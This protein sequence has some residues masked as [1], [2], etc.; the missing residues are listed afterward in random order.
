MSI[1]ELCEKIIAAGG[2]VQL[3]NTKIKHS[4]GQDVDVYSGDDLILYIFS[5]KISD[6]SDADVISNVSI[7]DKEVLP[8]IDA[9]IEFAQYI[10]LIVADIKPVEI[11][12]IVE[13]T[14]EVEK[15]SPIHM[16]A[17]KT[18]IVL[19]EQLQGKVEAYEKILMGRD[20]TVGK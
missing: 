5:S 4:V 9:F 3:K 15:E 20:I 13:K 17:M 19:K 11:E 7:V 16:E 6:N 14:V 2:V 10:G 8:K 12:K 1:K 18:L